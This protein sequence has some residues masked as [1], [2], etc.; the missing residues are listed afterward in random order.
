MQA[1]AAPALQATDAE[2]ERRTGEPHVDGWPLVSGLPA[3]QAPRELT[4]DEVDELFADGLGF[5]P[6]GAIVREIV[7]EFCRVNGIPAPQTKEPKA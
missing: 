3:P 7:A 6:K 1:L 5:E 2:L 4:R